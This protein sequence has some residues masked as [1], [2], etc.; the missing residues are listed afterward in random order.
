[1]TWA[2]VRVIGSQGISL[3][4]FA[5]LAVFLDPEDFGILGMALSWTNFIRSFSE[6]GF[7][8]ALIQRQNIAPKHLSTTF[9]MNVAAGIFLTMIGIALSWPCALFFRTP[10]V[11]P[12]VAILSLGFLVSAFSLTQI[13][14]AQKELRFR[15]LAI[16]EIPA[17]LAGGI[18][19]IVLA[20][21]RFGVWSLVAQSLI[22][23][24][25]GTVLLWNV[26]QWR[27]KF[28]EFSFQ[29]IRELWP[30]SSRIFLFNILKYFTQNSDRI[31]IGY[32]LGP[33]ALGIYTFAVRVVVRPIVTVVGAIGTYL[34]PK[35]SILQADRSAIE[36]SYLSTSKIINSVVFPLVVMVLFFS[37]ILVPSIWGAEWASVVP[38][39]Q[40]LT[41]LVITQSFISP[42]GQLMKALNRPGWLLKWSIFITFVG[43]LLIGLGAYYFDMIGAASAISVA[44]MLGVPI[45]LFVVQKLIHI[46]IRKIFTVVF[47]S[48]LS[49]LLMVPVFW[50][51]FRID[52]FPMEYRLT[53]AGICSIVLY[54]ISMTCLDKSFVLDLVRKLVKA[55]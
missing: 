52:R 44:Y 55:R 17:C 37:P 22:T 15:D 23:S 51:V 45:N 21:L 53:I 48:A 38:L 9:F 49:S 2:I 35:Y 54:I 28:G 13:T 1:M 16:R 42:A 5:L 50:L 25:V 7:G 33:A 24:L 3:L 14:I 34:F 29:C 47:P 36:A 11:Q 12:V 27:P 6:L 4:V 40:I 39:M 41:V 19:G 18:V 31:L 8:A 43:C 46:G 30:Y 32:L 20:W 10:D 26:S